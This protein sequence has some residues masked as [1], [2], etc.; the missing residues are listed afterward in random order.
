MGD[1]S[2]HVDTSRAVQRDDH[3]RSGELEQRQDALNSVIESASS[4]TSREERDELCRQLRRYA[5]MLARR[6]MMGRDQDIEDVLQD[7]A[8]RALESMAS[9][10]AIHHLPAWLRRVVRNCVAD[11][12]RDHYRRKAMLS[13]ESDPRSCDEAFFA[14]FEASELLELLMCRAELTDEQRETVRLYFDGKK[15]HEVASAC[16]RTPGSI[17]T[18]LVRIR[19]KLQD[20]GGD[21]LRSLRPA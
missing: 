6:P 2:Y 21:L 19:R 16:G 4:L 13:L 11:S 15:P 8:V 18:E 12:Y 17:R 3:S 14:E 5:A 1:R 9:G 7:A 20:R 10:R